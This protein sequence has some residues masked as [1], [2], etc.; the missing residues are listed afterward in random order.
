MRIKINHVIFITVVA[1]VY[2]CT[3]K[4]QNHIY[5]ITDFGAAGDSVT[6]NTSSIQKAIDACSNAGGGVVLFPKGKFIT[7]TLILKSNIEYQFQAGCMLIGSARIEH[8]NAPEGDH[9]IML[10]AQQPQRETLRVLLDGTGVSNIS[11]TGKGTIEG[12]G[13]HFWDSEYAPLE[14]PVPWISFRDAENIT[15]RDIT[16]QNSPSHVIRFQK[17]SQ[18][19]IDGIKIINDARSPNTDG[20]DLVDSQNAFITNSFISTGDDAICLKTDTGGIVEN[21]VVTNCILESDDAAIKFGTGSAGITRFCSFNNITINKSRYGVSLFMLEGGVFEMNNFS[22]LI[23][24]KGSRHKHEYPIFIDVDKKRPDDEYG[25]IR[26]TTFTNLLIRSGGKILINGRPEQPIRDLALTNIQFIIDQEVDFT[27]ASKPRGNKNFPKLP[28]SIDRSSVSAHVTFGYIDNLTMNS[29]KLLPDP[30]SS[31][32][33][34]D[35]EEVKI[36]KQD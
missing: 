32:K 14:R 5:N 33:N 8:Y 15:I 30:S 23:I 3:Q 12:N 6:L 7:G 35:L 25:L 13:K 17:S 18:I 2:A 34:F 9:N 1:C 20:I 22:N 28:E 16:F 31:R 29:I 27:K 19:T 21:I 36:T 4:N 10:I 24:N 11:F 26:N